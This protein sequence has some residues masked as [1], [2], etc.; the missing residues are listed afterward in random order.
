M[1]NFVFLRGELHCFGERFERVAVRSRQRKVFEGVSSDSLSFFLIDY[2]SNKI[3]L[4]AVKDTETGGVKTQDYSLSCRP[5]VFMLDTD[6]DDLK[7]M[8]VVLKGGVV[9][10]I[11][12]TTI[13][14][15][16]RD[17]K[18]GEIVARHQTIQRVL[19][20]F[21][22]V[23]PYAEQ[24]VG[25]HTH[26][27]QYLILIE[28]ITLLHQHQREVKIY[29]EG[30]VVLQYIETTKEDIEIANRIGKEIFRKTTLNEVSAT[31][32][33]TFNVCADVVSNKGGNWVK[34]TFTRKDI[35]GTGLLKQTTLGNHLKQLEKFDFIT[36]DGGGNGVEMEYRLLLDPS[37]L[38][39][40]EPV[41]FD[42][43]TVA[44]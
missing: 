1:V 12:S 2:L 5:M 21:V 22:V 9:D 19:E 39:G 44:A 3:Q 29:K 36:V 8:S 10:E 14:A 27:Q 15:I 43:T 16:V 11:S 17:R 41:L 42:P 25:S 24:I 7:D 34:S 4:T 31:L 6:D 23:N 40:V 18:R 33:N 37:S 35:L 30:D 26:L 32:R 28:V 38:T 20:G 13:E